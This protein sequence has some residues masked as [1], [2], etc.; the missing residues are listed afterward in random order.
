MVTI[1]QN[2]GAMLAFGWSGDTVEEQIGVGPHAQ[3]IVRDV[4]VGAVVLLGRNVADDLTRTVETLNELQAISRE[5]LLMIADQEGGMVA[6]FVDGVTLFPSYMALGAAGDPRLA[7]EA[8]AATATEMLAIGVN[9]NFAP[10]VDVNNNPDNPIIGTRSYAESPDR[11]AEF[12]AH[13]VRG[14]QDAGL[15][16]CAKHFPGHGDTAVDSHLALPSVPYPTDRLWEVELKPFAAAISAGVSSVMTTHILFPALDPARPATLSPEV[17]TGLLR[18]QMGYDGVVVTDCMEMKAIADV[19]GTPEAAVMAIEAGVD[20]I[21]VCH[22]RSVQHETRE[23]IIRAVRDGRIS[24]SR[25]DESVRRLRSLKDAYRMAERRRADPGALYGTLRCPE[26]LALQQR[27]ARESVT[28]VRNEAGVVPLRLTAGEMVLVAGLHSSVTPLARAVRKHWDNVEALQLSG[29]PADVL[30]RAASAARGAG[31]TIVPTCPHEPWKPPLDQELQ[32]R[33]VRAL[34]GE[35]ANTVVV[36]VREPYDIRAFP[37]IDTYVCTYGYRGGSLEAA[38][39]VIFGAVEP[40]GRLPVTIPESAV[41]R[42]RQSDTE[43]TERYF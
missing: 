6:R 34:A 16:A 43:V 24:E 21:L 18:K 32:A 42:T 7:Y 17:V 28:L 12:A 37:E 36:A 23:A 29:E 27:I 2:V 38:A 3:E 41:P 19:F 1:E 33:L 5:P 9:Y 31:A 15:I 13:A 8:A 20:L 22:T 14:Y 25:L 26:H 30:Q 11:A 39:D 4:E 40:K 10:C 35:G